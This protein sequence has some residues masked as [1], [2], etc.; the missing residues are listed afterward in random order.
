MST[1]LFGAMSRPRPQFPGLLA[2]LNGTIAQ[3]PSTTTYE[4][5]FTALVPA[6]VLALQAF[7][8][9]VCV[10]TAI[11]PD[12]KSTTT[13]THPTV[14]VAS[15]VAL[16]LLSI[17]LYFVG[18]AGKPHWLDAVRCLIPALAFAGWTGVQSDTAINVLAPSFA[19]APA[20][21]T[22]VIL[23]VVLG[24]AANKLTATPKIDHHDF[25]LH[26]DDET[27]TADDQAA[28]H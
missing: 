6:E 28:D 24:V 2:T 3:T 27:A 11:G 23:A 12:G 8:T 16:V 25:N 10:Q 7:I 9:S 14:L 21:V 1:Y 20:Q 15:F 13:I 18:L 4:R 17:S 26:A 22:A 19:G 5:T